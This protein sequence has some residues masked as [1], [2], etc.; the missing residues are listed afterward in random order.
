MRLSLSF[1]IT[2]FMVQLALSIQAQTPPTLSESEYMMMKEAEIVQ[3]RQLRAIGNLPLV[4]PN[5]F[6]QA[7][8]KDYHI[9]CRINPRNKT[10]ETK[11][12][13]VFK[14]LVD[15]LSNISFVVYDDSLNILSL[16][17]GTE[18]LTYSYNASNLTININLKNTVPLGQTDSIEIFYHGYITDQ[19]SANYQMS[20]RLDSIYSYTSYCPELWY[21]YSFDNYYGDRLD[22]ISTADI[23][24]TVPSGYVALSNGELCDSIKSD[25]INTYHWVVQKPTREVNF[26]IAPY[27]CSVT[28]HGGVPLSCYDPTSSDPREEMLGIMSNAYGF[29]SRNFGNYVLEKLA[30]ADIASNFGYG[31]NTLVMLPLPV[32]YNFIAHETAHQW[33]G[34]MLYL[35][36]HNEAWLNEGF[37]SYSQVLFSEDSLGPNEKSYWLNKW[38]ESY[39][40][41]AGNYGDAAIIPTPFSSPIYMYIVYYK[42]AWVLNMLREV[43]GDSCFYSIMSKYY[44]DYA[45]GD[46]SVTLSM[47]RT[48]AEQ[49]YGSDMGW[50]FDQWLY[51]AGYPIYR[52]VSY[53]NDQNNFSAHARILQ[54]SSCAED[55]IVFKVPMEI[56][57]ENGVSPTKITIWDSLN[58]QD[59]WVNDTLPMTDITLDPDNKILKSVKYTLPKMTSVAASIHS[60]EPQLTSTWNQFGQDL[61]CAGYNVYRSL[62]ESG[63]YLRMNSEIIT[64][65]SF[66]DTTIDFNTEYFYAIKAVDATDTCF[67]T[68]LSNAINGICSK[69]KEVPASS[70]REDIHAYALYQNA[71]NPFREST[72]ISYELPQSGLVNVSVYNINGQLVRVLKD[73]YVSA[74]RYSVKWDGRDLSG[75]VVS[76]GV[77]ICQMQ[78][79]GSKKS[80]LMQ[81]LR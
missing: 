30:L 28:Q 46:S 9:E 63:P 75:N 27:Y 32:N 80:R 59:L 70:V 76:N 5:Q 44:S 17:Q 72:V 48:S 43:V 49:V 56:S 40:Y 4:P 7:D 71:P 69:N 16:T 54:T 36:Y 57:I 52:I 35:R 41:Y 19:L 60:G 38:A 23:K 22:D 1:L 20:G 14:S 66:I 21:P 33:W 18:T 55:P 37:A 79:E 29:Y 67:V 47:F 31:A 26:A 58:I 3:A 81:Y 62:D 45:A 34:Q 11:A 10:I 42:G 39:K 15:D 74:G 50:F 53:Y 64:D 25:S 24:L 61:G 65:T 77:Y 2:L 13:I 51:H 68:H 6:N 73:G 12:K 8:L 78:S